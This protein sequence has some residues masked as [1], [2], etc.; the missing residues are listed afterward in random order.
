[1]ENADSHMPVTVATCCLL[2]CHLAMQSVVLELV[3]VAASGMYEV[4]KMVLSWKMRCNYHL[5]MLK[6]KCSTYLHMQDV[7]A[8]KNRRKPPFI[9]N[10]TQRVWVFSHIMTLTNLKYLL[11]EKGCPYVRWKANSIKTNPVSMSPLYPSG[12]SPCSPYDAVTFAGDFLWWS[13][14]I[15]VHFAYSGFVVLM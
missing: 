3:K 6:V 12:G 11:T 14:G 9:I 1:M 2:S 13:G 10:K 8:W 15:L 7:N 4:K 5:L